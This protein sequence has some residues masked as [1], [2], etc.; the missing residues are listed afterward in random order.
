MGFKTQSALQDQMEKFFSGQTTPEEAAAA[1][2]KAQDAPSVM[3]AR[4]APLGGAPSAAA[5]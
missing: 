3:E 4:R 1:V 2:Q 5:R